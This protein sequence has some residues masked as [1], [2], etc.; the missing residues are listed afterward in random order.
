MSFAT[1]QYVRLRNGHV[2]KRLPLLILDAAV[3]MAAFTHYEA[4]GNPWSQ[5][6]SIL[7]AFMLSP[8]LLPLLGPPG[9]D[10]WQA[11]AG[12]AAERTV[13][14]RLKQEFP[15]QVVANYKPRGW[16][17]DVDAI[18]VRD[19]GVFVIEVK[20]VPTRPAATQGLEKAYLSAGR[21][22]QNLKVRLIAHPQV[23]DGVRSSTVLVAVVGPD[24]ADHSD[25]TTMG[26][27]RVATAIRQAPGHLMSKSAEETYLR[28]F[29]AEEI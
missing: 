3:F 7:S 20:A 9:Y 16:A 21:R 24:W 19:N 29:A 18:V 28:L 1:A 2:R 26:V 27:R 6:I 5:Y 11:R 14:H 8:I 12:A 17:E 4:T 10:L 15:G 25:G 23:P 22:A 13:L